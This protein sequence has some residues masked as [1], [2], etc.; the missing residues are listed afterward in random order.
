[1][2]AIERKIS[3]GI[4][5]ETINLLRATMHEAHEIK[6]NL[7]EDSMD[8]KKIIVDVSTC[9]YIDSTFFGALVH[10]YRK[11]KEK[12]GSMILVMNDTFLRRT[13]LFREIEKI[14]KVRSTCRKA[15]NEFNKCSEE[16]DYNKN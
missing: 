8:Y 16:V 5:V 6:S 3:E 12:E 13:F 4:A 7:M 10:S 11:I 2:E 14:F 15:I 1:M 9:E